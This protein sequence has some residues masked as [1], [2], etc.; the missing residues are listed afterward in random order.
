MCKING[1]EELLFGKIITY[2]KEKWEHF[3]INKT[4]DVDET[5]YN[6]VSEVER[7]KNKST[8]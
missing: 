3:I 8:T 7:T 5:V 4:S 6:D 1:T 2:Y